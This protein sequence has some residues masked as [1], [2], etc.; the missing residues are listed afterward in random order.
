MNRIKR[1][2]I[3]L[4]VLAI[5]A[6]GA[7]FFQDRGEA[8]LPLPMQPMPAI[9]GAAFL[10]NGAMGF[11][12]DSAARF[13]A[14]AASP[15][16]APA[17]MDAVST[18]GDLQIAQRSIASVNAPRKIVKT[19][20]V[21]LEVKDYEKSRLAVLAAA[22]RYGAEALEDNS[23]DGT[24]TRSGYLVLKLPA[25]NLDALVAELQKNGRLLGRAVSATNMGEEYVDIQSRLANLRRVEKRLNDLLSF[26]TNRLG[27]VLSVER[28]L[29]R[30]GSEI[31]RL[32]GRKKYIDA[33][34]AA[35]R[36]TI[37][38][39]EPAKQ[40]PQTGGF[41]NDARNRLIASLNTF[42]RT[43]LGLLSFTG[44]MLAVG[45]WAGAVGAIGWG[46]K[47]AVSLRTT[48]R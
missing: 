48:Q 4:A 10:K 31:E 38:L 1:W 11:R 26:K 32:L 14:L 17:E 23:N 29:E 13:S 22:S 34:A 37:S 42:L 16:A 2:H 44:F 18:A 46:I 35:S 3:G 6:L 40:N 39:E 24:E 36:L 43:G 33:L 19:G 28:E 47:K 8:A 27:D 45:L 21:R 15:A 25:E 41:F 5:G 9:M 12:R 30:V 20:S 7:F